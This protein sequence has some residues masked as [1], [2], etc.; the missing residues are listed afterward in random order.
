MLRIVAAIALVSLVA[1]AAAGCSSSGSGNTLPVTPPSQ[2]PPQTGPEGKYIKHIVVIVQENRTFNDIFAGFKGADSTLYGYTHDGTK[3]RLKAMTFK[4]P[5]VLHNWGNAM[6]DW[7]GGRMN[8]FDRSL[9]TNGKAAG[10]YAYAY[11]QHTVVAPYWTMATQYTLA[12]HMFP[13]MFGPTFTAHI[14][15]I[16]STTNLTA[17][18]AEVDGPTG[19]PWGCDAPAGTRTLLL[20]PQRVETGDGPFPCFTQFPTIAD[21]LDKAHV[22]WNVYVDTPSLTLPF[23]P[24][25]AIKNVREGPDWKTDTDSPASNVLS[26]LDGG[27]LRPVSFVLSPAAD[28]DFPGNAGGPKW[29]QSIVQ[30]AQKSQY[31]QHLAIVVVWDDFGDG[32]FYDNVPPAFLDQM[33]LGLRVPLL[34]ISPQ[35]KHGYISRTQYEYGSIL[36]YIEGNWSLGTL[37]ATDERATSIGDIFGR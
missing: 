4:G 5:D 27:K 28:S 10:T 8:G 14:D 23:D 30:H 6:A 11:I 12:D 26:D 19:Q 29:V 7:N 16:A 15:L 9:Y 35:V 25:D 21:L 22:G 20:N 18:E 13:T 2:G 31:W 32:S 33:G 3:V 1:L 17:D 36:K 37:G 24:F 34:V